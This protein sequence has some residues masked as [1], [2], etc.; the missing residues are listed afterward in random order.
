MAD[1]ECAY[2]R[3]APSVPFAGSDPNGCPAGL[4]RNYKVVVFRG[5]RLYCSRQYPKGGQ[6]V[7]LTYNPC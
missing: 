6:E 5:Y 7:F 2:G 4:E 1:S 3:K